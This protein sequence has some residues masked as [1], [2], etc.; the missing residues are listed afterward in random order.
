MGGDGQPQTIAAMTTRMVDFGMEPQDAVNAP[1]WLL[2][3]SW[4]A[5]SNDLKLEGRIPE[6]VARDLEQR[7]H[8]VRRIA[9]FTEMV[10][11]AGAIMRRPG[12]VWQG[13][14]DPRG[15]GQAAAL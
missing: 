1:R 8:A 6:D 3:R 13:A 15:D 10:G 9:D 11:H 7:G 2:G 5:E 12:D 4:G 14:T